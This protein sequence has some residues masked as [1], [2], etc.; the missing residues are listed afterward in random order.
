MII[1]GFSMPSSAQET[2]DDGSTTKGEEK[3]ESE[4]VSEAEDEAEEDEAEEDAAEEDGE[5]TEDSEDGLG[6]DDADEEEDE[7]E[8]LDE[9]EAEEIET[10]PETESANIELD[11]SA[12]GEI[13]PEAELAEG[14]TLDQEAENQP[15]ES[16]TEREMDLLEIH[17]YFRVRPEL[18][19]NFSIRGD[20]A[21]YDRPMVLKVNP[22]TDPEEEAWKGEDCRKSS[23]KNCD[24]SSSAGA[25]MRFRLEPTLNI[26][27]EV[28]VKAQ[29]DFLDNVMLGSTPRYWQSYGP[30]QGD[31]IG[32]S[33]VQ[34]WDMGPPNS[35]DMVVVRRAWGEVMTPLGQLR[36]GRMGDHWGLGMLHNSGNGINQDFGN[37]VDRLM[38]AAKINDWLIA[39]AFDFPSDGMSSADASGRPFDVSQ[40]DDSYRLVGIFAY[41]HDREE[42][43]AMLKRGDWLINTGLYFSY[44]WQVLSFENEVT[45]GGEYDEEADNHFYRRDM[46]NITP[47]LWFQFLVDTF[48]LEIE[49]ALVYGELGNPDRDLSNYD[50]ATALTLLQWGGV[51]Q[52]DY[53]LLSDQLRIG[54]E[55]GFAM[56]DDGVQGVRAPA[57]YDQVNMPGDGTY[58]SFAFNPAYNTDLI[59]YRHILGSVSQSYYFKAW[60]RYDF[61]KSAMGRNLG[62]QADV[63]YSRAVFEESTINGGTANLGVELNIKAMYVSDDRFHA[64]IAYGVLFPLGAFEGTP[65]W[66]DDLGD[67]PYVHD[68]DLSIPQTVQVLLGIS[69]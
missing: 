26:S 46:W 7:E 60:L 21:I 64:G 69:Y 25:N 15:T 4:D 28:W 34:G 43:L 14:G 50:N 13:D 47:D 27:E 9:D 63:L 12:L 18:Y 58:S 67:N 49:A 19:D 48:H 57:T 44:R 33:Q 40:L 41:K 22:S 45:D 20:D 65:Y 29:M 42:Q 55:S 32:V 61:L 37:S 53:G 17:G 56:G 10:A 2:D 51:L 38:F 52:I 30:V 11:L 16:W 6:E 5:E 68:T 39:P 62:I 66:P 35:S 3:P 54:L 59:L 36:F 31:S 1:F 23:Y 8:D 24:N